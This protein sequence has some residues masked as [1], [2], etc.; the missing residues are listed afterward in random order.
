MA[1]P[2][3]AAEAPPSTPPSP[4]VWSLPTYTPPPAPKPT[5]VAPGWL[6]A[7][8]LVSLLALV[9]VASVGWYLNDRAAEDANRRAGDLAAQLDAAQGELGS[10]SGRVAA[11]EAAQSSV[12]DLAETA[13]ATK[14]SVFTIVTET[15]VGSGWVAES[16]GGTSSL[17]TNYHVVEDD[18]EAGQR[19]VEVVQESRSLSGRVVEV[20]VD[21][22]LALVEVD[23]DLPVL[24]L[25]TTGAR[26]GDSVLVLGS[27]LGLEQTV[28]NGIVSAFR[29]DLIQF[30]A[31][32]SPGSSGGPVLNAAG[33]V[34]GVTE[35]KIAEE[36]A[37]G[38]G[39]AI[40]VGTLCVTVLD[41]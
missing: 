11:L 16:G 14:P 18:Y 28:V 19:E 33:E 41:C 27:P 1:L 17:V 10:L 38:L 3:W 40:P 23:A 36:A 39:F 31:P 6:R 25:A 30:S 22:D 34:I 15:G 4:P 35:L 13:T 24:P 21:E 5:D 8:A 32:I 29:D 7:L 20:A 12:P 26:V 9:A 37:E 2:P